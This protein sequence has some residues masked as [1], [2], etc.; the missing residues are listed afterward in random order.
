MFNL[1]SGG[2][3]KTTQ[4]TTTYTDSFNSTLTQTS[5][6]D[7]SGQQ[8]DAGSPSLSLYY[9]TGSGSIGG[10]DLKSYL[11]WLA[12]AGLALVAVKLWKG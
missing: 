3:K 9:N 11:P 2:D 12:A 10:A 8:F 5:I 6:Y 1:F 4:N 7:S